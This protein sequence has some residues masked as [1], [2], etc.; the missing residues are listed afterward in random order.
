MEHLTMMNPFGRAIPALIAPP[1][2]LALFLVLFTACGAT[3]L[4][5]L[6]MGELAAPPQTVT[7]KIKGYYP[8]AGNV[9]KNLF[10]SNFSVKVKN[11]Q[12]LPSTSRDGFADS[13]KSTL[14]STFGFLLSSPES[15]VTGFSD[16]LLYNLG[17]SASSQANLYCAPAQQ[18]STSNDMIIYD[19]ERQA[20]G[21]QTRVLGLRDCQ[22]N[23]IG[24]RTTLFDT[25]GNGIPDYMKLRC[26]INLMNRN[27]AYI[28]TASDGVMDIDKCKRHIPL[29][30]NAYTQPNQLY[31]YKYELQLNGDG[32]TD[33]TISNIPVLDNGAEQFIAFYM[34]E[35][36]LADSTQSLYT[37]YAVLRDG[38]AGKVI[39][40]PYWAT[41]STKYY[42]QKITVQ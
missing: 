21:S 19:D 37:A 36:K 7:F 10:V 3:K 2:F 9:Y 15:V 29:D 38:D 22:K 28:S 12:L 24:L 11:G 23:Y 5:S 13:E 4:A 18:N 20:P 16:L 31:A 14:A 1:L 42:N 40:V 26:G 27:A 41:D 35:S 32:S 25:A 6:T 17:I 8:Q 34:T 30:E 33:L 39:E